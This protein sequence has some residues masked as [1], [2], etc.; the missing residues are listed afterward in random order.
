MAAG[1]VRQGRFSRAKSAGTQAISGLIGGTTYA[2]LRIKAIND[3]L[4][5]NST[6][7]P[8]GSGTTMGYR[9]HKGEVL[10]FFNSGATAG[11]ID[12][13]NIVI[14]GIYNAPD[15]L[16]EAYFFAIDNV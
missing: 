6:I 2:Y 3:I 8:D 16:S 1:G 11:L 4:I 10:E 15:Q 14:R 7:D 12:G 13:S 5:G 9:L